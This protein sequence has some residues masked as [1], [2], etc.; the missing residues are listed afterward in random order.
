MPRI[1]EDQNSTVVLVFRSRLV[2][3]YLEKCFVILEQKSK[4]L[5][6]VLNEAK[7]TTNAIC[8]QKNV[9]WCDTQKFTL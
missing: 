4:N 6:S 8:I 3:H 5:S 2:N 7:Q 9:L 1:H